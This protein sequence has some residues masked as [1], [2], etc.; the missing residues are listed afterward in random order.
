MTIDIQDFIWSLVS[1]IGASDQCSILGTSK[2]YQNT[3]LNPLLERVAQQ[4][5][6]IP[7]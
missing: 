5:L 2:D 1:F 3:I 4:T 6:P 7:I